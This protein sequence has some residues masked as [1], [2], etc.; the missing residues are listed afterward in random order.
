MPKGPNGEKRPVDV[1][2]NAVMI[3]RMATKQLP[4]DAP[5]TKPPKEDGGDGE[6]RTRT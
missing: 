4:K 3:A 2:E 5:I 1:N 6:T